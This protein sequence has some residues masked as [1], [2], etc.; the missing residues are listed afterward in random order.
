MTLKDHLDKHVA[1]VH[2][3]KKPFKCSTCDASFTTKT[4]LNATLKCHFES[5]LEGKKPYKC[6]ICD[7]RK[8]GDLTN[9]TPVMLVLPSNTP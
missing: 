2:E 8:E 6:N 5:I 4:N 1:S 9:V 3:G 7:S